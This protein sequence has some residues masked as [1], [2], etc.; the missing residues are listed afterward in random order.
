MVPGLSVSGEVSIV[1]YDDVDWTGDWTV[2]NDLPALTALSTG[3]TDIPD[4]PRI[5]RGSG[6]HCEGRLAL[7]RVDKAVGVAQV[8]IVAA[9]GQIAPIRHIPTRGTRALRL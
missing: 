4:S 7:A 3:G 1:G 6:Q 9:L 2:T 5:D 8:K